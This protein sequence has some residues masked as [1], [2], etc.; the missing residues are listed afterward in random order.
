[1]SRAESKAGASPNFSASS[2]TTMG[3]TRVGC[4]AIGVVILS[5]RK[6]PRR[7]VT[8][9]FSRAIHPMTFPRQ[10]AGACF[11]APFARALFHE[12][13][14]RS[15]AR[16][17]RW[18]GG[19]R[20]RDRARLLGRSGLGRGGFRGR[21]FLGGACRRNRGIAGGRGARDH[22]PRARFAGSDEHLDR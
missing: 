7:K 8:S 17:G 1:C 22:G 9:P 14:A 15:G 5:A 19:G 10:A 12:T 4:L 20:R 11:G 3:N 18:F 6:A 16:P 2:S 13:G 21:G